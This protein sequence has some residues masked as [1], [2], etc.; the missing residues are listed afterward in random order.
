MYVR[1]ELPR[2][3][4][5]PEL[6]ARMRGFMEAKEVDVD[7]DIESA[8]PGADGPWADLIEQLIDEPGF[9]LPFGFGF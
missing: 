5:G 9:R 7:I 2:A 6:A 8:S 4:D 3:V 1:C